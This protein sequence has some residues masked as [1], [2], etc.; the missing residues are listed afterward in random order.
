M[1]YV[2]RCL[3][4]VIRLQSMWFDLKSDFFFIG[5]VYQYATTNAPIPIPHIQLTI[6]SNYHPSAFTWP[7]NASNNHQII[8]T[9]TFSTSTSCARA[10]KCERSA[11]FAHCRRHLSHI[12]DR[13]FSRRAQHQTDKRKLSRVNGM[14]VVNARWQGGLW[15]VCGISFR[16][17]VVRVYIEFCSC[18]HISTLVNIWWASLCV[19]GSAGDS[20]L[21]GH[22][23]G[24]RSMG[25]GVL[26][27]S[28]PVLCDIYRANDSRVFASEYIIL[29]VIDISYYFFLGYIDFYNLCGIL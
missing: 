20:A 2:H 1:Y 4:H 29:S 11:Q 27:G 9:N 22:W 10:D 24:S 19:S 13:A 6:S 18:K 26:G 16:V 7:Q 15:A 25:E 28:Q 23:N 17:S 14:R 8:C 5:K 3:S 12:S 21:W